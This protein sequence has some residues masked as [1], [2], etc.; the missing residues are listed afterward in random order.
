MKAGGSKSCLL[1][2]VI[3]EALFKWEEHD[4]FEAIELEGEFSFSIG[5]DPEILKNI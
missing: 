5:N 1:E 2:S 4:L 3:K